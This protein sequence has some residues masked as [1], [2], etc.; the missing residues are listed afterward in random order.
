ME[1]IPTLGLHNKVMCVL[2]LNEIVRWGRTEN[3]RSFAEPRIILTDLGIQIKRL[4]MKSQHGL[5][6][7]FIILFLLNR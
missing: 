6:K 7:Q 3:K 1:N 2:V 4:T 5:K